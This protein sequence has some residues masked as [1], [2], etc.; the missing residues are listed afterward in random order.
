ML[1]GQEIWLLIHIEVQVRSSRKF[2][3]RVFVYN[4]RLMNANGVDVVSLV[5][6]TGEQ[7]GQTGRFQMERWGCSHDFKFP[8][9]RI[10]DYRSRW[11]ELDSSNNPFAVAVKAQLKAMETKGDD[12]QRYEWKRRLIF[13]LY[14]RGY[15]R[16]EIINLFRFMDWVVKI[17]NEMQVKLDDEIYNYELRNAMPYVTN[18]ERRAEQR[19]MMNA[20]A[21]I[22]ENKFGAMSAPVKSRLMSLSTEQFQVLTTT[23]LADKPKTEVMAWLKAQVAPKSTTRKR[24]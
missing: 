18:I 11:E 7:P 17:P 9:V 13:D 23:L 21:L 1:G 8:A 22:W 2:N 19:G 12:E 20:V 3:Q 16:N 6:L 5:V 14:R 24:K 4:Y 15:N 10:I